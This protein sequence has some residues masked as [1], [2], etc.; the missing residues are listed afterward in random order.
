MIHACA[1]I[2]KNRGFTLIEVVIVVIVLAI[3][4]PPTLN[5]MQSA[6]SGRADAINTTRATMLATAVM[7]S[8]LADINSSTEGLGFDALA[9]PSVYLNNPDTGLVSRIERQVSP[10]TDAG[11]TYAV[12]ISELVGI[13]AVVTGDEAQDI[14]RVVTVSVTFPSASSASY[15]L[16]VSLLVSAL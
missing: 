4:V 3:A 10:Y 5:L 11:F 7:E 16:P 8:V 6:A 9:D 12:E 14:F 13:N 2:P 15:E 1:H